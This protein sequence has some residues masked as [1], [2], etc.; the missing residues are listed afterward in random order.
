VR[1]HSAN[2]SF[3]IPQRLSASA[4]IPV[5]AVLFALVVTSFGSVAK[6]DVDVTPLRELPVL[7]HG[8]IKPIDTLARETARFVTGYEFFGTIKTDDSGQQ[9]I[10]A[11]MDPLALLMDWVAH[12]NAW[13][14]Q[15]V[16]Y[17]PL[18]NLRD[19]LGMQ[20]TEEWISARKVLENTDFTA[21]VKGIEQKRMTAD[22]NHE[23]VFYDSE[24]EQQL[25]NAAVQLDDQLNMFEAAT[26]LRLIQVIPG[27]SS[28]SN[29][30]PAGWVP[31]ATI[32]ALTG[33][34]A[35]DAKP[36]TTAWNNLIAAYKN[37]DNAA[38]ATA[39]SDVIG[40]FRDFGG[41]DY[42]DA[43]RIDREIF[44]NCMFTTRLALQE[45]CKPF[46]L[47][48][49][50]YL[51]ATCALIAA[52][53]STRKIVYVA[54]MVVFALAILFH[55]GAF[56][57]RC[58]VTGW[59]PVTN[60]YETVIWVA[61]MGA[62]FSYVLELIY[63]R[64]VLAIGGAVVAVLATVV[65]DAMPMEYGN[66]FHNLTPVLRSNY[67]LTIHV[68]TIVSSYAAF[69]LALVLGNIVLGQF[70]Y[71]K[72]DP[73]VI[74][75]NIMFTYRAIQIGVLLV[76]TGTILG[77]L[78]AAES[79]GRFWGWDPKEVWALIVFLTYLALLHGRYA[80]WIKQFGTAAGAVV[81]FT[82]VLMS[83]YGVNFVLGAGLHSYGFNTG[84]QGYVAT[85]V[86]LQWAYVLVAWFIY[87]GR[88]TAEILPRGI[89]VTGK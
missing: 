55:G 30:Q 44:Y 16:L 45:I 28:A 56:A 38:F 2:L 36:L 76:L 8:R 5:F 11:P 25:E 41:P 21:W 58:S 65:A 84:G 48:W 82:A 31:M 1:L 29:G 57:L 27:D 49:I 34:E 19:K 86:A 26:D 87:R 46:R 67:W 12:P 61:M 47:A 17:V 42:A 54:A 78:W 32:L 83:W 52:L 33:K 74:R 43:S 35:D 81:C 71:G 6:A 51:M 80:G 40:T 4:F 75:S 53:M 13:Q 69:A 79:W 24:S 7:D 23:K 70:I 37:G 88:Q 72:T 85:F 68:L 73:A 66:A 3:G 62:I 10:A 50:I 60:M 9:S 63:R 20:K 64:R 39:S 89:P 18:L 14:T 77:G 15:P 59:A 22:Q